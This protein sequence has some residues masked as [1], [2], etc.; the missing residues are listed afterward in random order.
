MT[1]ADIQK[2]IKQALDE[3]LPQVVGEAYRKACAEQS[4][5]MEQERQ[6]NNKDHQEGLE[7]L[8]KVQARKDKREGRVWKWVVAP[9]MTL[10]LGGGG[11]GI[12]QNKETEA[13][14]DSRVGELET[15][16]VGCP[17]GDECSKEKMKESVTGRVDTAEKKIH[18]LGELHFQQLRVIV[19]QG[20]EQRQKLNTMS[21]EAK[22][23]PKPPSA[24]DAE[25]AVKAHEKL[26]RERWEKK[27]AA[28]AAAKGD[29][30]AGIE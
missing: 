22:A 9:L 13:T 11:F 17:N 23:I 28:E 18:R 14:V 1:E 10:A 2:H 7:K 15:V 4:S 30:F 21:P 16:I 12:Y 8:E 27:N 25:E 6:E 3:H 24:E 26:K 29:P 20:E 19:D 5:I